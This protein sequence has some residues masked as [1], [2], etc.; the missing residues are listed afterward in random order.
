M[1]FIWFMLTGCI[2]LFAPQSLTGKLQLAFVD[3]FR[4]PLRLGGN[5]ALTA[6]TQPS[7][8][9]SLGGGEAR[10]RIYIANLEQTLDQQ[11]KEFQK[12]YGLYNT[13]V[14]EGADWALAGVDRATVVVDGPRNELTIDY[15]KKKGLVKGQYVLGGESVI[16]TISDV[17]PQLGTAKVKLVTD[18]SSQ[19]P[20]KIG[21][22]K[23]I[24]K[25]KGGN[26][27]I[28]EMLKK[29]VDVGEKVF[30]YKKAGFLDASIIVGKVTRCKRNP[31]EAAVWDATVVPVCDIKN[32]DDVA[33]I[34]MNPNAG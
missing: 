31:K 6:R 10:L 18:S 24:M 8:E 33:V 34:I 14:W 15:R 4:W 17:F 25:G 16:G 21:S 28:V 23:T 29:Q 12:L 3:I 22:V 2:L 9:E 27:A 20:V 19:I 1:L 5:V 26:V 32:L 30:A 7:S 11:R 13:Y